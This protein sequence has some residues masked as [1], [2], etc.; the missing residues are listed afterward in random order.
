[1]WNLELR[2][3]A[4]AFGKGD[5]LQTSLLLTPFFYLLIQLV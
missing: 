3:I 1:M 4:V 2:E 5:E